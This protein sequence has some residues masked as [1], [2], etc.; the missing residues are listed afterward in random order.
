MVKKIIAECCRFLLGAVFVFSGTVKAIDPVGGAIK[1]GDYFTA[2]G[3]DALQ[4][5]ALLFSFCLAA[6]EF[7]LGICLLLG[8]YRRYVSLLVL[9]FML[10][11]T[12]LTLYLA[13]TDPVSDCGCFGDAWVIT[14]WQTFYKNLVL[15]AAAVV[16]RIYNQ[17]LYAFYTYKVYWFVALFAYLYALGFAYANYTKLPVVDFRPYRVGTDIPASMSIPADAP[18]AEYAYSF[19]YEKDGVRQ[20]F[21][22]DNYPADDST[23][24]FVDQKTRLI[25]PGY[26]PPIKDFSIYDSADEAITDRVLHDT[27]GVFLL[28]APKLEKADDS[29]LEEINDIYD[30]AKERG[31]AFYCLTASSPEAIREWSDN[32]G[33]EYPF[34]FTDETVLKT[35][36]RSNPGLLLLKN[37]VVLAKWSHSRLPEE[38][39][40]ETVMDA[41]LNGSEIKSQQAGRIRTNLLGFT[42]PLLLVYLY[43]RARN[44]KKRPESEIKA[45]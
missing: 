6:L 45:N 43:D 25:R 33:A 40:V 3:L 13:L 26:E 32:T 23:W 37:G 39:R 29:H 7:A 10:F 27:R 14:N 21:T 24:T 8:V 12:P 4:P 16:V 15:L 41:Y 19:L 38:D 20:E 36:I 18:K 11:M 9:L 35:M 28:V 31:Y 2:F 42:L 34:C 22:L 30:Y 1:F 44:R 5:F 17:R